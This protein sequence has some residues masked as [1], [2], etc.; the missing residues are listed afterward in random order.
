[1]NTPPLLIGL[2]LLFW[3]WQTGLLAAAVPMALVLEAH[4]IVAWRMNLAERDFS[5]IWRLSSVLFL[6]ILG[7]VFLVNREQALRPLQWAPAIFFPLVAAQSFSTTARIDSRIFFLWIRMEPFNLGVPYAMLVLGAASSAQEQAVWFFPCLAILIGWMLWNARPRGSSVLVW[8]ALFGAVSIMGFGGAV[9]LRELQKTVESLYLRSFQQEIDTTSVATA[10]G[11]IGKRKQSS[12]VVLRAAN[13]PPSGNPLY[14]FST[15][16][17]VY[18]KQSWYGVKASSARAAAGEGGWMLGPGTPSPDSVEISM[19]LRHGEGSLVLLSDGVN[20]SGLKALSLVVS[21]LGAVTVEGGPGLAVFRTQRSRDKRSFLGPPDESDLAVPKQEE[22]AISA[23]ESELKLSSLKPT[24]ALDRV[25]RYFEDRFVYT[26]DLKSGNGAETPLAGFLQTTRA[27][28]C[29]YFA[30]A[31]TLLLRKAGVPARYAVGYLAHEYSSLEKAF[32]VRSRDAHAWVL[33]WVDGSWQTFDPT[34]PSWVKDEQASTG[35]LGPAGD[36]WSFLSF[37]ISKWRWSEGS[38]MAA[39]RS[40]GLGA[41]LAL[42]LSG[43]WKLRKRFRRRPGSVK[44]KE[45]PVPRLGS[46]SPFSAVERLLQAT[47]WER[48]SGETCGLW[49]ERI[50]GQNGLSVQGLGEALALHYRYRFDPRG[51]SGQ[52]QR[53]LE[54]AVATWLE[55]ARAVVQRTE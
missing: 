36:L 27:G 8:I 18:R 14:L 45:V 16:Y 53:T 12:R 23:T 52:E 28:H 54:Q 38:G 26:L 44:E 50:N 40:Y 31:A 29:E 41:V 13:I 4:R 6:I 33:V 48:R 37:Q 55:E 22:P 25:Q 10:I 34:P 9:S 20:V 11:D 46:D 24:A 2:S 19:T 39:Y 1:M 5:R 43:A 47:E 7:V 35:L 49:L 17:N 32:L 15:S 51:I 21:R 42:V 3:G 30:T